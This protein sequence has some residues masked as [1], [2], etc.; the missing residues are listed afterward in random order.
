MDYSG[1]MW[2]TQTFKIIVIFE[3]YIAQRIVTLAITVLFVSSRDPSQYDGRFSGVEIP[4]TKIRRYM[5][6]DF[7]PRFFL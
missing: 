1:M 2:T 3:S 4:I 5:Y 7:D 6:I